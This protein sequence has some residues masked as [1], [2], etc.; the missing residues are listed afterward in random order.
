MAP[1]WRNVP[2]HDILSS[3]VSFQLCH[4]WP[5]NIDGFQPKALQYLVFCKIN[6]HLISCRLNS[7]HVSQQAI[8]G[9]R[10]NSPRYVD[11]PAIRLDVVPAM[12]V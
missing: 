6:A 8:I 7:R 12:T 4:A 10:L 1:R 9:M 11:L 3:N 5:L 2:Y